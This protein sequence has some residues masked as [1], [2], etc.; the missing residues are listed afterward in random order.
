MPSCGN[1]LVANREEYRHKCRTDHA[2]DDGENRGFGVGITYD[3]RQSRVLAGCA[4]NRNAG[5]GVQIFCG[6][7]DQDK[8]RDLAHKVT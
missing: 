3:H 2:V 8:R 5:V 1:L 7:R 6:K 4:R